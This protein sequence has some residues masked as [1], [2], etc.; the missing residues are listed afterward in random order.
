MPTIAHTA[1]DGGER[2][3]RTPQVQAGSCW[4]IRWVILCHTIL[5]H[6]KYKS[7]YMWLSVGIGRVN[8]R[9]Y[10]NLVRQAMT[11]YDK[12]L[13]ISTRSAFSALRF[14]QPGVFSESGLRGLSERDMRH[15][16]EKIRF[17]WFEMTWNDHRLHEASRG[18]TRLHGT[19]R[20]PFGLEDLPQFWQVKQSASP[21]PTS[22]PARENLPAKARCQADSTVKNRTMVFHRKNEL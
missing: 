21:L 2:L 1:A 8:F 9:S 17:Q 5:R 6:T 22:S 3:P 19:G 20:S 7:S 16:V 15:V 13:E 4:V 11:S 18:F 10:T 14:F 12:L